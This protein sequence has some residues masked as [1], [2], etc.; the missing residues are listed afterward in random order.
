HASPREIRCSTKRSGL[1]SVVQL[2]HGFKLYG[3][4]ADVWFQLGG[5]HRRSDRGWFVSA[6][7]IIGKCLPLLRKDHAQEFNE[8]GFVHAEG[9]ELWIDREAQDGGM[10]FRRRVEGLRRK[11]EKQ[12]DVGVDLR[13]SRE[14][15]VLLATGFGG[16]AFGDF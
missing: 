12:F 6:F 15:S 3:F 1:Q 11:L 10:D 16:Y 4:G 8:S 14:H 2:R 5:F 7:E 13:G 9:F